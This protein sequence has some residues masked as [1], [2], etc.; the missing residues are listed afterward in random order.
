MRH[1]FIKN[2]YEKHKFIEQETQIDRQFNRFIEFA[3]VNSREKT[4]ELLLS[5]FG[6]NYNF[7]KPIE[8]DVGD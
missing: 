3:K 1:S 8:A 2:K 4:F 6:Q 5:L 7:M